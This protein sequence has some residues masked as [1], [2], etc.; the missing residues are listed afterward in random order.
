MLLLAEEP[1]HGYQL[2]QAIS[3]RSGGAW[4]PSP[5]AIYP[6][7]GQLEDEGLI[8]VTA[9]SGRR[10]ASLTDAGRQAVEAGRGSWPDPFAGFGDGP[11]GPDLRTLVGQLHEAVRQ[12]ARAGNDTDIEAAATILSDARRSLYLLL[13]GQPAA[14]E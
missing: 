11:S 1:M 14:D 4:R 12:V 13:A 2:M 9:E 10:L 7:L 3:D 6:L 5:G 8:T